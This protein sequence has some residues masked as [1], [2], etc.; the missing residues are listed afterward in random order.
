MNKKITRARMMQK[1]LK[2]NPKD[3]A[4]FFFIGFFNVLC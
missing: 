4:F 3:T 1:N 2:R